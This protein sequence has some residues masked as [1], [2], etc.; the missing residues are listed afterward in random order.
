MDTL[1][2]TRQRLRCPLWIPSHRSPQAAS[3]LFGYV[4]RGGEICEDGHFVDAGT[5]THNPHEDI[6]KKEITYLG[7]WAYGSWEYP[8]AY[9]FLQRAARIGLP[10]EELVTHQYPLSRLGEAFQANIRQEGI[11]LMGTPD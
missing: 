10:V 9:H 8:N 4:R 11:K 3:N 7:S 1:C 5:T 6:C 2:P